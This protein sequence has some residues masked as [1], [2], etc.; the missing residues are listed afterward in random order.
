M[1]LKEV[2]LLTAVLC[3]LALNSYFFTLLVNQVKEIIVLDGGSCGRN[4]SQKLLEL[5]LVVVHSP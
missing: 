4:Q 2:N 1:R 3:A 5:I